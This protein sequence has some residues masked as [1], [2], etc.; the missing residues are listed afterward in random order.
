MIREKRLLLLPLRI[1]KK[2]FS[3]NKWKMVNFPFFL[4]FQVLSAFFMI[5]TKK[6]FAG[7]KI[8]SCKIARWEIFSAHLLCTTL[9]GICMLSENSMSIKSRLPLKIG[10]L[11][12]SLVVQA[13]GAVAAAVPLLWTI[14]LT[15]PPHK[16]NLFW[17]CHQWQSWFSFC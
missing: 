5:N 12:L 11:S 17:H 3:H 6:S 1:R 8:V 10:I 13:A 9:R 14:F 15:E 7:I 4:I 2:L 16:S